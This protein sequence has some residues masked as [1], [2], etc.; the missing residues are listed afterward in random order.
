[1]VIN[2]YNCLSK[3]YGNITANKVWVIRNLF[4]VSLPLHICKIYCTHAC[5]NTLLICC[6]H[7]TSTLNFY[8]FQIFGDIP[9]PPPDTRLPWGQLSMTHNQYTS[10]VLGGTRRDKY[11]T[12]DIV[13]KNACAQRLYE[14]AMLALLSTTH[15]KRTEPPRPPQ[16][17]AFCISR[18]LKLMQADSELAYLSILN[19]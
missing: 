7:V 4:S 14:P 2:Y 16:V 10:Y 6:D 3:V 18:E 13:N 17:L 8:I 9:P 15:A 1:M 5:F 19:C 12:T 11:V